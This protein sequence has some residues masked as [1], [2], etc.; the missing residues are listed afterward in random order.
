MAAWANLVFLKN[1]LEVFI[2]NGCLVRTAASNLIILRCFGASCSHDVYFT[3]PPKHTLEAANGI[4]SNWLRESS[5]DL[6][7]GKTNKSYV[8][9]EF[10][11]KEDP[12]TPYAKAWS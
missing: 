3:G 5:G 8:S 4:R 7:E 1:W 12:L 11:G 9:L 6:Q 2:G 10:E